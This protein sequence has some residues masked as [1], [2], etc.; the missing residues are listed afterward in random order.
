MMSG[1]TLITVPIFIS[2]PSEVD[3]CI[4]RAVQAV[5]AGARLLEWRID[6]LPGLPGDVEAVVE[7]VRRSPAPCIVTCRPTWEGGSYDGDEATR[8]SLFEAL[9]T[10]DVQARYVDIELKAYQRS[11]NLRQKVHLAVEHP[12]QKRIVDSSLILSSHDFKQRPRD[13]LQR[14]ESMAGDDACAVIKVA[15]MARS[16]RDNLQVFELLT[17]RPKPMIALC[18]GEF[19]LMSRVLAPKFG[20][21]A[22]FASDAPGEESAPGQPTISELKDLFR[23]DSIGRDTKV[24]GVIGWPV[25]QSKSPQ[26]HNA[27]FEAV[28][29]DGVYLPL[30]IPP[31]YEHFKATVGAMIDHPGLDFRG[32]S[33][34]IPHK[35]NLLRFVTESGGRIDPLAQSIG[36]ANTL[37]IGS[38]GATACYNTDCPAIIDSLCTAM[39]IDPKDLVELRIAILGAGGVARAAIAGLVEQGASVTIFNRT[40]DKAED[41][42]REWNERLAE[43]GSGGQVRMGDPAELSGGHHIIINCTSLGMT[44][45]PAPTT[46]PLDV[47]ADGDVPLDDRVT[48]FDTVYTPERTPLILEA[49]ARGARTITGIDMFI[50]QAAKQFELWTGKTAPLGLFKSSLANR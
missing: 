50:S 40:R 9:T 41:L 38:A 31:E 47:L 34:T 11:A 4:S 43:S 44:A 2:D 33:V 36:A 49:E 35:E 42:A 5:A 1:M 30:P 48:V 23:F 18:M 15:W 12:D 16:L 28:G 3:A 22:T 25:A 14:I 32:A 10:S 27:G 8:I 20:S 17:E 19:G 13:L 26:I 46:S 37:V 29:H 6:A 39:S 7:L 24:Y 21:L 45:G